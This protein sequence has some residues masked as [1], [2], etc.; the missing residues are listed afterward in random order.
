MRPSTSAPAELPGSKRRYKHNSPRKPGGILMRARARACRQSRRNLLTPLPGWPSTGYRQDIK[1]IIS[2]HLISIF[3][4]IKRSR[5]RGKKG[6]RCVKEREKKDYSKKSEKIVIPRETRLLVTDRYRRSEIN[7][8]VCG[9][10]TWTTYF[11]KETLITRMKFTRERERR[12]KEKGEVFQLAKADARCATWKT[13]FILR[14]TKRRSQ[15]VISKMEQWDLSYLVSYGRY[16]VFYG[17]VHEESICSLSNN[18]G[19]TLN[20]ARMTS[21]STLIPLRAS[22]RWLSRRQLYARPTSAHRVVTDEYR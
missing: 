2:S 11:R 8:C 17:P 9:T 15:S 7:D 22:Y 10:R 6:E 4:F 14:R 18:D 12:G 13:R 16:K 20:D 19:Q 1:W 21:R 5:L 3:H